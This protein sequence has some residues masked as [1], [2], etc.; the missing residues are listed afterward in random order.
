MEDP[1]LPPPN[2]ILYK[3]PIELIQMCTGLM[4]SKTFVSF[5]GTCTAL[6][7]ILLEEYKA[8]MLKH[9]TTPSPHSE[10][11]YWSIR[12]SMHSC[13]ILRSYLESGVD[14]NM[15]ILDRWQTSSMPLQRRLVSAAVHDGHY[16]AAE[17]L[18]EKGADIHMPP[19]KYRIDRT[20]KAVRRSSGIGLSGQIGA[21]FSSPHIFGILCEHKDGV[22]LFERVLET[23]VDINH[24]YPRDWWT[25]MLDLDLEEVT[26][27]HLAT[28]VGSP[29]MLGLIF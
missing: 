28:A 18:L 16:D 27:L 22:A 29:G 5:R 6:K 17:L 2:A 20:S 25:G 3:L 23:G 1:I 4:D 13:K 21:T 15:F 11:G 24:V 14:P 7:A 26:V 9:A 8:R 12:V 19:T 10:Q